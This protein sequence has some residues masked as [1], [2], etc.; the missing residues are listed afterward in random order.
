MIFVYERNQLRKII[1]EITIFFDVLS[2]LE[3]LLFLD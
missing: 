2:V 1:E 3:T